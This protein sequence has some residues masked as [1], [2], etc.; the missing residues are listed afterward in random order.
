M[1]NS[2]NQLVLGL[3]EEKNEKKVSTEM[4][5]LKN[6]VNSSHLAVINELKL[7][8]FKIHVYYI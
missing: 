6:I 3:R 8:L 5:S 4:I 2:R 7:A 1:K